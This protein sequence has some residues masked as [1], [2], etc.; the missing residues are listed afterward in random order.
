MSDNT[1]P[2]PPEF[3]NDIREALDVKSWSDD[4]QEI[5][6]H[7]EDWRGNYSGHSKLLLKPAN[8]ED[9]AKAVSICAKHKIP[10]TPQ[11]GNTGLVNGGLAYGEVILSLKRMTEIRAIDPLNNSIIV[12]AGCILENVHAAATGDDRFFPLSLGSQGSCSIGGLISTNA[13]GVAVL[14]YGMMR[15]LILGLEVVTPDGQIWSGLRGLRKDNTGYDLKHLFAGAE[16]TLGIVTAA[17][18][19]LFPVPR[20][21]TA[22]LALST[23]EKAVELLSHFRSKAG[24][25]VT[26][27][28]LM[29][30]R[31][32]ELTAQEI[33]GCRDPAPSDEPWRILVE[34]SF[35][36]DQLAK[37]TL[38]ATLAAAFE[39]GLI[40]DGVIAS[41]LAQAEDFWTIR[42]SLPLVK[43]SFL[44]SVNH[45]ISIPVSKIPTFLEENEK[46]LQAEFGNV[47]I[48]A[49]GHLGDGNLHYAVAEPANASTP[50][51]RQNAEAITERVHE[52]VTSLGGSI[53]AEH[54]IGLL[55]RHE[56]P[57]HKSKAELAMMKAI[58]RALD[59]HNIMNPGRIFSLD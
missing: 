42:E 27:F 47:E 57:D 14:R 48:F 1:K 46:R 24:D 39:K 16:G 54:G 36:E 9:V 7:L 43:R 30:K 6:P 50:I 44:K 37:D 28:E 22:W 5:A 52:H 3:L 19:K 10:I 35:A 23:P 38:E 29:H 8:T 12:E 49:F 51:V 53:S 41:S 4:P 21:A 33:E 25:T 55:K 58:K 34:L 2:L 20:T 26:S 45:D 59:P 56:L 15:D 40:E 18:L 32:V 31:G 11:G 17:C 13:G